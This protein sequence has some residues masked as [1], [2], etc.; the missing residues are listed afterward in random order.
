MNLMYFL[1]IR[2]LPWRSIRRVQRLDDQARPVEMARYEGFDLTAR[3]AISAVMQGG[4]ADLTV[5]MMLRS[6]SVFEQFDVRLLL[7]VHD[8]LVCE[9][10]Q[11]N[12]EAFMQA[13]K[14]ILE[15]SPQG[16][17]VPVRVDM[18]HGQRYGDCK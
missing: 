16:F 11:E 4:T 8:E 13:W 3:Q 12:R 5:S 18:G 17:Q 7:Q 9:C 15:T 10:P 1:P 2:N 14:A 6:R